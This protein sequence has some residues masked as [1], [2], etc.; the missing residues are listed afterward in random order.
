MDQPF[1]SQI[2]IFG[3]TTA[4]AIYIIKV[5]C[6]GLQPRTSE[7]GQHYH[8]LPPIMRYSVRIYR[9]KAVVIFINDA[10][11]SETCKDVELACVMANAGIYKSNYAASVISAW[12]KILCI[13][14]SKEIVDEY[15]HGI[16]EHVFWWNP[17]H[18]S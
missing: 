4:G 6:F 16:S 14:S 8:F 10:G 9:I 7:N 17:L 3:R 12:L 5:F 15:F 1:Q 11:F 13:V 2:T 18:F